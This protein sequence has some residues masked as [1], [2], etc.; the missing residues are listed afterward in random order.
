MVPRPRKLIT[1]ALWIT[2]TA[3]VIA[4]A[5]TAWWQWN[6]HRHHHRTAS[7]ISGVL[8]S[9][10]GRTLSVDVSWSPHC[11][12]ARPQ[13]AARESSD[14]VALT[15]EEGLA[16]RAPCDNEAD[17]IGQVSVTLRAPLGSRRLV[18]TTTGWAIAPQ[19]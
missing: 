17:G 4:V 1:R 9:G 5:A 14:T 3:A 8:M 2:G 13:L 11:N 6:D 12:G 18:D 16:L 7:L 10:D 19:R 15:L